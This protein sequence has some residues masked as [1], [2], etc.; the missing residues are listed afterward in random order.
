MRRLTIERVQERVG[1]LLGE[2]G[3]QGFTLYSFFVAI[4]GACVLIWIMRMVRKG[5]RS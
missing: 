1:L 4:L 2:G 5:G 3:V